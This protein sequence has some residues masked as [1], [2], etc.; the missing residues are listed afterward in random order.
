MYEIGDYVVKPMNGVCK[1]EDI[2]RVDMPGADKNKMYY[3]L[4]PVSDSTGKIYAPAETIEDSTRRVMT[5]QEANDLI[6]S[7]PSVEE[8]W[9]ENEKLRQERYKEVMRRCDPQ[10]LAAMIK[11]VYARRRR[12][13]AQGKK[14]TA[15]DERFFKMAEENLYG[16]LG[17]A[18]HKN[19]GEIMELIRDA[20]HA[21]AI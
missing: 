2:T 10:E 15:V 6:A 18:L 5:E 21:E 4:I 19:K 3:L 7:I 9:I 1:V 17:F 16:E 20:A 12:R 11:M 8:A 14:N 13:L